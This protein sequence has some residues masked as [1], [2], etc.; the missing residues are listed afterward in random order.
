V[1]VWTREKDKIHQLIQAFFTNDPYYPRP[2]PNDQ[3]YQMFR[4]GYMEAH[5]KEVKDAVELAAAFLHGIEAEQAKRDSPKV[6]TP[7]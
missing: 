2:R 3:L 6:I 4:I 5:P 1:R 7:H